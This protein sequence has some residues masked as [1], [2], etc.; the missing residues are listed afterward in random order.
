MLGT[1][2][3]LPKRGEQEQDI[4]HTYRAVSVDVRPCAIRCATEVREQEKHISDF[5][6]A[7]AV[8]VLGA[9][10]RVA[11]A[12]EAIRCIFAGSCVG[13]VGVV[14]ASQFV[15]TAG[16]FI[17]IAHAIV[18]AVAVDDAAGTVCGPAAGIAPGSVHACTVVNR[19]GCVVIAR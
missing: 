16:D 11:V 18:I 7:V 4:G 12:V 10:E 19:G 3:L 15:L 2:A 1:L 6:C 17:F 14:I 8:D 13:G 9:A 5:D